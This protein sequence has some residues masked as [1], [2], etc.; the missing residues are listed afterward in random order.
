MTFL[1]YLTLTTVILLAL[2][3]PVWAQAPAVLAFDENGNGPFG[4]GSLQADP[5][6][7]GLPSVLTY[8]LPFAV[9][10]GD[11][12]MIGVVSDT[13]LSDLVRFNTIGGTSTLLF[14]SD[15]TDADLALGDTPSI[16]TFFSSNAVK[17]NEIGPEGANSGTYTP[18]PGQ[19]GF[20]ANFPGQTFLFVSDGTVPGRVPEPSSLALLGAG[21]AT[22]AGTATWRRHRRK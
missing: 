14:Y 8:S 17:L 16:P 3:G 2:A 1:R 21:L 5:T 9:T 4:P 19:P 18:G 22:L 13:T 11:V 6:P 12:V 20:S 10:P 15:S 7:G